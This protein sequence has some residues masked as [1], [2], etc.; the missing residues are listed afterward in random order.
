MSPNYAPW[1]VRRKDRPWIAGVRRTA[2][3]LTTKQWVICV[4]IVAAFTLMGL[5][6]KN[7]GTLFSEEAPRAALKGLMGIAVAGFYA[8]IVGLKRRD[9]EAGVARPLLSGQWTHVWVEVGNRL[10]A[11]KTDTGYATV[12][13]GRLLYSGEHSSF[14]INLFEIEIGKIDNSARTV[15]LWIPS[16]KQ[17][18]KLV[19][20][21]SDQW[22]RLLNELL[23]SLKISHAPTIYPPRTSGWQ[24]FLLLAGLGLTL[25]LFELLTTVAWYLA[26]LSPLHLQLSFVVVEI[27]FVAAV[28]WSFLLVDLMLWK[29]RQARRAAV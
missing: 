15:R 14:Q 4:V 6:G 11:V 5:L 2:R 1:I 3:S 26:K 10:A 12:E 27:V 17:R 9:F 13:E 23:Q 18:L 29:K 8:G 20:L 28:I 7:R 19:C 16:T 22:P 24:S 25:L 21:E